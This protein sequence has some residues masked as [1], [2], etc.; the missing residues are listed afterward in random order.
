MVQYMKLKTTLYNV[1]QRNTLKFGANN[2]SCSDKLSEEHPGFSGCVRLFVGLC[3]SYRQDPCCEDR[4]CKQ[5]ATHN[6]LQWVSLKV[7][8]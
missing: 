8:L 1:S 4:C 5:G 7:S 2:P 3:V 6:V